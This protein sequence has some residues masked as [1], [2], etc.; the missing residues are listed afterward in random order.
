MK[1]ND[2][3]IGAWQ[4]GIILFILLFANKILV[5]PSLLFEGAKVEAIF[6]PVISFLFELGLLWLFYKLK[7]KFPSVSFA[8]ILKMHLG[9]IVQIVLYVLFAL[10]FFVKA[11]LLY[12]VTYIFFRNVIYID[13]SNFLFLFCIL[14]IINHLAICGLRV[15][16][17]T[18]QMF[19]PLILIIVLFCAIVGIF[20][21]NSAPLF[22]QSTFLQVFIT[23]LRHIS[24]F[25]DIIFAFLIIDKVEIKKKQWKVVFILPSIA[26]VLVEAVTVVYIL[27]YTYTSF[28]HPY[29]IFEIVSYIKEYS[30]FGRLDIIPMVGIILFTYFHLAIYIKAFMLS[31]NEIF[32]KIN[33]IYSVLTFNLIFLIIVNYFIVNLNDAIFLA[34]DILPYFAVVPFAILPIAIVVAFCVKRLKEKRNE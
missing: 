5:L 14:P 15:I 27:S 22:F 7:T 23:G 8:E 31:F 12:N 30:G 18:A 11:L 32:T 20:D 17:R 2:K 21:I 26:A 6:I 24:T 9:K 13:Y 28:M 10:F 34:Q 25:G 4:L 33:P 16:G 19:F 1:V 29:A 3:S